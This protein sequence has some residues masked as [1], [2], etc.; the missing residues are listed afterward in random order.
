M[1]QVSLNTLTNKWVAFTT[2]TTPADDTNYYIQNRGS[3]FLVAAESASEPTDA[4]GVM[5]KPF[6]TL[7]YKKGTNTLYLRAYTTVCTINVSSEG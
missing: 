5:V 6:E 1:A 3:D 2:I 7:V 4:I